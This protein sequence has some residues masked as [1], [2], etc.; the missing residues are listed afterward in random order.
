MPAQFGLVAMITVFIAVAES[1]RDSGMTS[2]LIRSSTAD[3]RDYNTVFTINVVFSL[4]LYGVLFMAAPAIAQ[5]FH[6]P[7]LGAIVR[8]MGI[9][10]PINALASVQYTRLTKDM[11][12]KRQL[13]IQIPSVIGGGVVGIVMAY[14]DAGVWSLVAQSL[15]QAIL[16]SAQLWFA[17]AWRPSFV[18]YRDRWR[19]HFRFGYKL[20]L[21]GLLDTAFQHS[22]N[23]II[24][25]FF[26][27]AE[28]GF[29]TRAQSTKQL[30]V[31]N[32]SSALNKVTYPLFSEI[33]SDD[34]K[35]RT[36]YREL[37]QQILFW[38]TPVMGLGMVLAEPLFRVI[39]TEKWLPSVPYFQVLCLAAVL[40]P[41][42]SYNL[43]VLKVKGRTD[44]FLRVEVIKKLV[45]VGFIVGTLPYGIMGLIWGQVVFSIVALFINTYYSGRLIHYS[46]D[47]Q[48]GDLWAT[49][50]WGAA[51]TA[52]AWF[53]FL[54]M[55]GA[56]AT[57]DIVCMALVTIFTGLIYL[58]GASMMKLSPWVSA[59][60][61][62]FK[63]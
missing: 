15:T 51:C 57:N 3:E 53:V 2:S 34:Q 8:V 36:A 30:P 23:L 22:Y 63:K 6:Q 43:N 59:K 48:L 12:F 26:S 10:L 11:H 13:Q 7:E 62:L 25:K 4:F 18:I 21:S 5:F 45:G 46:L 17:H 14:Q 49:L 24:G 39:F 33:Q 40:H 27:P 9:K 41:L 38:L 32:L 29:Y 37:M 20:T 44:L 61:I 52:L 35:L 42:H 28:V 58:T 31:A 56:G 1:L 60:R 19:E 55:V 16:A 54:Q 50:A 47:R